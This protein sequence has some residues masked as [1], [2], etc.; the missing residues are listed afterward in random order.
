ML[1]G[2]LDTL[3]LE[4]ILLA[5]DTNEDVEDEDGEEDH[6]PICQ[7]QLQRAL[8]PGVRGELGGD[9]RGEALEDHLLVVLALSPDKLE[10]MHESAERHERHDAHG[11]QA[12]GRALDGQKC[13]R[14]LLRG[15]EYVKQSHPANEDHHHTQGLARPIEEQCHQRRGPEQIP[16]IAKVQVLPSLAQAEVAQQL[17]EL[18]HK[19][20]DPLGANEVCSNRD[21]DEGT[22]QARH[23]LVAMSRLHSSS[24]ATATTGVGSKLAGMDRLRR[25][26]H[27]LVNEVRLE[28]QKDEPPETEDDLHDVNP[29]PPQAH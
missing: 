7:D 24:A 26:R 18:V 3:L 12:L 20:N 5:D 9:Q 11:Q 10:G 23:D 27:V 13:H 17:Q 19:I 28:D 14:D 4:F 8:M 15:G 22:G 29:A 2:D 1:E 16:S 6:G 25:Q 21:L